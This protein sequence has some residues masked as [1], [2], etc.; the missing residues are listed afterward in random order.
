MI[1]DDAVKNPPPWVQAMMEKLTQMEA[2]VAA[3][4]PQL[5][6]LKSSK[7]SRSQSRRN[8]SEIHTE[9]PMA[10]PRNH[11][12]GMIPQQTG[13]ESFGYAGET[14]YPPESIGG[15]GTMPGS[16]HHRDG[17]TSRSNPNHDEFEDD[18]THGGR[19]P[20]TYSSRRSP[21]NDG[22]YRRRFAN[23]RQESP[24]QQY[25][26]EELYKLRV[27]QPSRSAMTHRSWEIARE[28]PGH[29]GHEEHYEEDGPADETDIPE[30]EDPNPLDDRRTPSPP[31]PP[32][33]AEPES[34]DVVEAPD[35]RNQSWQVGQPADQ[36]PRPPPWQLIHQRLLNWAIVWP[37]TELD[38]ALNSTLAGAQVD[39]VAL[40]IWSTQ[41]YK[42]YVR[43][44]L[45]E[46][47]PGRVD[48]LFVPPNMADAINNAVFHGRHGDA[49]GM[50]R[51]LWSPFGLEGM[52]RIIVVLCKHRNDPAH[53]VAHK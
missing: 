34:R 24:G 33:P 38:G 35:N 15:P 47:P 19:G 10:T 39:E 46:V 42:R 7:D 9:D 37:M 17:S 43:Q 45:T 13:D 53:W 18:E 14:D 31:L 50:L 30:I 8:M 4:G 36:P 1:A 22:D 6:Q 32:I 44:Q 2:T 3:L 40:S 26:E 12:R 27:R 21:T 41:M 20:L 51:D 48:R 49:C 11:T 29:D 23:D 16:M 28:T 25:L 5:R 52:P